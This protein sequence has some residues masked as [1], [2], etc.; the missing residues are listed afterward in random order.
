[1]AGVGRGARGRWSC[2]HRIF[3]RGG[4]RGW[5]NTR[6]RSPSARRR[7]WDGANRRPWEG[8]RA[9]VE[10]VGGGAGLDVVEDGGGCRG[11]GA[12]GDD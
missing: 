8:R 12:S 1:M 6:R 9:G 10:F 5:C 7:R 4:E 11:V 2:G 3:G